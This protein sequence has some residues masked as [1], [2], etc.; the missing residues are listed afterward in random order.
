[1]SHK[2][3]SKIK[4]FKR[5]DS[6]L[7]DVHDSPNFY[8]REETE[9]IQEYE[10]YR[11]LLLVYSNIYIKYV[12]KNRSKKFEESKFEFQ[13]NDIMEIIEDKIGL[14]QSYF[15][16]TKLNAKFNIDDIFFDLTKD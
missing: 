15:S 6:L 1:M 8:L 10:K 5:T 2:S 9:F 3:K 7:I 11:D 14:L 4:Q 16:N 13:I 12:E